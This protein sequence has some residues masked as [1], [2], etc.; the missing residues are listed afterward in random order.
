MEMLRS[1]DIFR[2]NAG[3]TETLLTLTAPPHS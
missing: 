1:R 2:Q 3:T